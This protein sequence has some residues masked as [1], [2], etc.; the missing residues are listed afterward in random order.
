MINKASSV[1]VREIV[2]PEG[3]TEHETEQAI[4]AA[5]VAAQKQLEED[6]RFKRPESL[7]MLD[8]V[9]VGYEDATV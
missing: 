9:R 2:I 1:T 4:L 7:P 8:I 5:K 6:E 3:A